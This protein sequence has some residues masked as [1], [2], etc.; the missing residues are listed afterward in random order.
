M[1]RPEAMSKAAN[2]RDHAEP[3]IIHGCAARLVTPRIAS[4]DWVRSSAWI[5]DF[6]SKHCTTQHQGMVG[7]IEVEPDDIAHLGD[8]QRVSPS[9]ENLPGQGHL[10]LAA[11]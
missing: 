4:S 1:T 11:G 9:P 8:K 7:R 3:R 2:K 5:C 6:S 10:R